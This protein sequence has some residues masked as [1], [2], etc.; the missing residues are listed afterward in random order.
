MDVDFGDLDENGKLDMA[1]CTESSPNYLF[2]AD[3]EGIISNSP[4]WQSIGNN[5]YMNS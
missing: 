2:V 3:N 5:N 1:F 4:A